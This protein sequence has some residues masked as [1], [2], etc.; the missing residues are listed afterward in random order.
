MSR[1]IAT[2]VFAVVFVSLAVGLWALLSWA[3]VG[4]L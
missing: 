1:A 2:W 3:V 4:A